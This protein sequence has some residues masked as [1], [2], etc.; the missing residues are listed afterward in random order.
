MKKWN[1]PDCEATSDDS[2]ENCQRVKL[3]Q[4][5]YT[6]TDY[7]LDLIKNGADLFMNDPC[8]N[9]SN[10]PRNGGKGFCHC[11]LGSATIY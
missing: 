3:T 2:C 9:C 6:F 4:V 7:G 5:T 1:C 8:K 10:H 11:I